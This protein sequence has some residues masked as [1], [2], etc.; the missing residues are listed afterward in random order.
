MLAFSSLSLCDSPSQV[1]SRPLLPFVSSSFLPS[2]CRF[3]E[4]FLHSSHVT[5][6]YLKHGFLLTYHLSVHL[7][8]QR[9][10]H[11]WIM[12]V[13]PT[14]LHWNSEVNDL[15]VRTR[16]DS[17]KWLALCL[18]S[19]CVWWKLATAVHRCH[20][21]ELVGRGSQTRVQE[22]MSVI[23]EVGWL[24]PALNGGY[25]TSS[26]FSSSS[27]SNYLLETLGLKIVDQVQ[28]VGIISLS[29]VFSTCQLRQS[30]QRLYFP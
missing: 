9:A 4:P 16:W 22:L 24:L 20:C 12:E 28:A 7:L 27:K 8:T 18:P 5:A 3:W 13:S 17:V 21:C 14:S 25:C 29:V 6:F 10:F 2:L 11:S 19:R 23:S 30:I 26:H 15:V 1:T